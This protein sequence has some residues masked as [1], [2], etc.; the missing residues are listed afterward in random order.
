MAGGKRR[1][2]QNQ[3]GA[4]RFRTVPHNALAGL[5]VA[6][7]PCVSCTLAREYA[8]AEQSTVAAI[9][10]GSVSKTEPS[11]VA[12]GDSCSGVLVHPRV[13]LFASHCG[14]AVDEVT[15][16]DARLAP[17]YCEAAPSDGVVAKDLAYCM[18]ASPAPMEAVVT[19]A[20][21]CED[22]SVQPGT[23]LTIKGRGLPAFDEMEASVTVQKRDDVL[24]ARGAGIGTCGGDSGGPALADLVAGDAAVRRLVAIV[25]QGSAACEEGDVWLTPVP[26][27]VPWLESRTGLDVTP[28]GGADGTWAPGPDCRGHAVGDAAQKAALWTFCGQPASLPTLHDVVPPVVALGLSELRESN[29]AFDLTPAVNATDA[30]WGVRE[31]TLTVDDAREIS[32]TVRS[33]APYAFPE[34]RLGPGRHRL[35]ATAVDFADNTESMVMELV[36]A[37]RAPACHLGPVPGRRGGCAVGLVWAFA[38]VLISRRQQA[39]CAWAAA[40]RVTRGGARRTRQRTHPNRPPGQNDQ[41]EWR[42]S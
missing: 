9:H 6:C 1:G 32:S 19:P 18:L 30:G 15:V 5:V 17:E 20:M 26:P 2:A 24:L 35:A 27:L 31:V 22:D 42:S 10:G 41:N 25:S 28:C 39:R 12:V 33:L 38:I 37:E 14:T 29:G 11:V 21:G 23:V 8:G 40:Q 7:A 13:V 36:L 4:H 3:L 16:R 34:L